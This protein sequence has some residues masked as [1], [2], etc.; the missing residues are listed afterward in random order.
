MQRLL[1]FDCCLRSSSARCVCRV[2]SMNPYVIQMTDALNA[3]RL[4]LIAIVRCSCVCIQ[5][6]EAARACGQGRCYVRLKPERE[7]VYARERKKLT[8]V[9]VCAWP[10]N[11]HK[12]SPARQ[13][14]E[15]S[16]QLVAPLRARGGGDQR[17]PGPRHARLPRGPARCVVHGHRSQWRREWIGL[18]RAH[19]GDRG[20]PADRGQ[21]TALLRTAC[22]SAASSSGSNSQWV[23]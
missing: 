15:R 12:S 14:N 18:C 3:T 16:Q 13:R 9:W 17:L 2:R 19:T 4:R 7:S 21:Y 22:G 10:Q 8:R 1:R 11:V 20:G 23:R 5:A 6:L